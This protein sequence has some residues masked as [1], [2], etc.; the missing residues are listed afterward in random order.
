MIH[1]SQ[2]KAC[3]AKRYR[4]LFEKTRELTAIMLNVKPL[5]FIYSRS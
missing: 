3:L 5:E 2:N 1:S 4:R